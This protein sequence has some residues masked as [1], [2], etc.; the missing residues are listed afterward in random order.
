MN[1][2]YM[3]IACAALLA[4]PAAHAEQTIDRSLP[5]GA[6]PV[7]EIS[8]V[9]GRVTVTGWD[10]QE[11][12]VTGTLG[13][14]DETLEFSGDQKHVV[15]KVHM[16][17]GNHHWGRKDDA[18]LNVSVPVGAQPEI[19]TVSAD[20]SVQGVKGEQRLNSVSGDVTTAIFD[21]PLDMRS[22]SG[23]ADIRG[24]GGKAA[25]YVENTSGD[26][27]ARGLGSTLEAK[28]VSGDLDAS[29]GATSS[30]RVETVSGNLTLATALADG[31]RL[32]AR[33]V[34]GDVT[35]IIGKP[36]NADLDVES[37]SGDIKNCFGPKPERKSKYAPGTELRFTQGNGSGRI[38][39]KTLSGDV[40]LCDH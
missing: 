7:V 1:I 2:R 14:D 28:T 37:F 20:I 8:N 30:V 25:V 5:T 9:Q 38:D 4:A 27:K 36:I 39:V 35:L 29:T 40:S 26:V 17:E 31:G 33:S 21:Q 11:V 24:S 16:K 15:I 3:T 19:E 23:D 6:A 10:R 12:K 34:S 32:N 13:S 18:I 22:I